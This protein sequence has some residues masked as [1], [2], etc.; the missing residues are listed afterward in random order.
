MLWVVLGVWTARSVWGEQP[1]LAWGLACVAAA[2]RWG[3]LSFAEVEAATRTVGP[4]VVA[5]RTPVVI[6]MAA[7]LTAAVLSESSA[8]GLRARSGAVRAAA[9]IAVL[10]LVPLFVAPGVSAGVHLALGWWAGAAATLT[11]AVLLLHRYARLV[12]Q[13]VLVALALSSL[14][15]GVL[16]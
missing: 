4:S 10:A 11:A 7:G 15:G 13:W 3:A 12:P 8:G 2:A 5:G 16:A 6:A 1:G 14:V 9:A